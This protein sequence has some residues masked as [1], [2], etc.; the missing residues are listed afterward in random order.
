MANPFSGTPLPT[1]FDKPVKQDTS[2]IFKIGEMEERRDNEMRR[3]FEVERAITLEQLD[4]I[5]GYELSKL[6][7]QLGQEFQRRVN[8][9][10]PKVAEGGDL[11]ALGAEI[12]ALTQTYKQFNGVY[13]EGEG[14]AARDLQA[15]IAAGDA[16]AINAANMN[17]PAGNRV[18]AANMADL[19]SGAGNFFVEGTYNPETGMGVDRFNPSG[20]MVRIEETTLFANPARAYELQTESAPIQTARERAQGEAVQARIRTEGGNVFTE[21]AAINEFEGLDDVGT[22]D[23]RDFRAAMIDSLIETGQKPFDT[24]EEIDDFVNGVNLDS[25]KN[26]VAQNMI[27]D[28]FVRLAKFRFDKMDQ[29][30]L[31]AIDR[32]GRGS[33]QPDIKEITVQSITGEDGSQ[34]ARRVSFD[35]GAVGLL[36]PNTGSLVQVRQFEI[37][38]DGQE[39]MVT[40]ADPDGVVETIG[41]SINDP[42]VSAIENSLQER[43]G[44]QFAKVGLDGFLDD[45]FVQDAAFTTIGQDR[46]NELAPQ[47]T[48]QS[49]PLMLED[50]RLIGGAVTNP[51]LEE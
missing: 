23:G 40:F 46:E 10:L 22:A 30:R 20:G 49:S 42:L 18:T 51:D 11:T 35:Q 8:L 36:D 26:K 2:D 4:T 16:A 29:A 50:G 6:N 44:D 47:S 34:V 1:R 21:K 25:H 45:S 24:Q 39:V 41:V 12:A 27:R 37:S 13:A 14:K 31:D 7:G 17:L 38:G 48:S 19:D 15:K 28:E 32:S 43:Y 33:T 5:A 3:R 9:L